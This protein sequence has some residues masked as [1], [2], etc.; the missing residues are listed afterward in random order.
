MT[1]FDTGRVPLPDNTKKIVNKPVNN[2]YGGSK[3]N[4]YILINDLKN[5]LLESTYGISSDS[6]LSKL[7]IFAREIVNSTPSNSISWFSASSKTLNLNEDQTKLLITCHMIY[8][9]LLNKSN[10]TLIG[11]DSNPNTHTKLY[12]WV[13]DVLRCSQ[14]I[15][16]ETNCLQQ[17]DFRIENDKFYFGKDPN[18]PQLKLQKLTGYNPS[19][20]LGLALKIRNKSNEFK[21]FCNAG[22]SEGTGLCLGLSLFWLFNMHAALNSHCAKTLK[23]EF[24]EALRVTDHAV[25]ADEAYFKSNSNAPQDLFKRPD[26]YHNIYFEDLLHYIQDIGAS[27]QDINGVTF[28]HAV[29]LMIA[30]LKQNKLKQIYARIIDME[31][32]MS[33]VITQEREFNKIYINDPNAY[34][35]HTSFYIASPEFSPEHFNSIANFNQEFEGLVKTINEIAFKRK[36][37]DNEDYCVN[38]L[39]NYNKMAKKD[40]LPSGGP[41]YNFKCYASSLNSKESALKPL[42]NFWLKENLN[43]LLKSNNTTNSTAKDTS[44]VEKVID[45]EVNATGSL[46]GGTAANRYP[47]GYAML[48]ALRT[49][50]LPLILHLTKLGNYWSDELHS[51]LK[52]RMRTDWKIREIAPLIMKNA[53]KRYSPRTK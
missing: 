16:L 46:I 26:S 23:G 13:R 9:Y 5:C 30:L 53:L 24:A 37:N 19:P 38:Y 6:S 51:F 12:E 20:R 25:M 17:I 29:L 1:Y 39:A 14:A 21:I 34:S 8:E 11:M 32:A 22:D 31:H 3:N 2:W 44:D 36:S 4:F 49:K 47:N 33:I 27:G 40:N 45:K 43:N 28:G 35:Q 48:V 41:F 15:H 7:V 42:R 18:Q 52:L 10:S 50:N